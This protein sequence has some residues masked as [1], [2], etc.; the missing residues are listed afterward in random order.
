GDLQPRLLLDHLALPRLLDHV[1]Q[2]PA[3]GLGQGPGLDDPDDIALAGLVALVVSVQRARAADDLLVSRVTAGDVDADGDR[4]VA[5]A[6][7]DDA[8]ANL[9]RVGL[10]LGRGGAG[11]GLV[12]CLG[13]GAL[14]AAQVGLRLALLGPLGLAVLDA[15]RRARLLRLAGF[16]QAATLLPGK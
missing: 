13:G 5:L 12:S 8:L 7:D 1:D 16:L 10:V 14:L 6:G 11:A 2:A 9:R 4:L 3:L 15:E